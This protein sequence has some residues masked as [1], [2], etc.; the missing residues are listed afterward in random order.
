MKLIEDKSLVLVG[1]QNQLASLQE[2]YDLAYAKSLQWESNVSKIQDICT[3]ESTRAYLVKN[4]IDD[5]YVAMCRRKCIEPSLPAADFEGKL[6]FI[7]KTLGDL[8]NVIAK[9]KNSKREK[10]PPGQWCLWFFFNN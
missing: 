7:N 1:L 4:S 6:V 2:R 5:T 9:M 8:E 10:K 3:H